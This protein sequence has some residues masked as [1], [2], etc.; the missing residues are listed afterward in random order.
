MSGRRPEKLLAELN[1]LEGLRDPCRSGCHNRQFRRFV[2]RGDAELHPMSRSRLDR[3][4][5][6]VTLRDVARGG[7]GFVCQQPLPAGSSWRVCFLRRGYVVGEQAIVVRHC[8][9]IC[10][11]VYLVGAQFVIDTGLLTQLGIDPGVI[12]DEDSDDGAAADD[13]EPVLFLPPGEVA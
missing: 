10:G 8:R 5:I 1:R 2:V 9:R 7:C 13:D 4:P 3:A 11:S 6:E 12:K